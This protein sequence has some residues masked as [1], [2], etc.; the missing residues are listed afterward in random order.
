M[1]HVSDDTALV[2]MEPAICIYEVRASSYVRMAE[3]QGI[4]L[5][6]MKVQHR[7]LQLVQDCKIELW[8][9]MHRTLTNIKKLR[10]HTEI[11]QV[12]PRN[13]RSTWYRMP[14]DVQRPDILQVGF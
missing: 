8:I 11:K 7:K 4:L 12:M 13:S 10:W 1:K 9:N 6:P 3:L 14:G 2:N 5:M